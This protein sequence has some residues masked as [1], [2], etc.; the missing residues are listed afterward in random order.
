MLSPHMLRSIRPDLR[1]V[2]FALLTAC[3]APTAQRAAPASA[4]APES[5]PRGPRE[6]PPAAKPGAVV[7]TPELVRLL[8]LDTNL[9]APSQLPDD[10]SL[11]W[12]ASAVLPAVAACR[13]ES[14]LRVHWVELEWHVD[15]AGKIRKTLAHPVFERPKGEPQEIDD[16]TLRCI[17]QRAAAPP[18]T[19]AK[20]RPV[21]RVFALIGFELPDLAGAATARDVAFHPEL[22]GHCR[23]SEDCPANKH[24]EQPPL[25]PCP[26]A[27]QMN[28]AT[29][30]PIGADE[31]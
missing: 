31:H 27:A 2:A 15:D 11:L 1:A 24:C 25:V 23:L 21:A 28:P 10:R 22:D 29:P 18:F 3:A 7:G 19:A 14:G 16:A 12:G 5:T 8:I 6:D 30:A 13:E 9:R 20:G 4:R 17:E 26:R